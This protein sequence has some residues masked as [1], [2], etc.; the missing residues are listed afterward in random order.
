MHVRERDPRHADARS[1]L[2]AYLEELGARLGGYDAPA[3]DELE[4]TFIA[5]DGDRAV[6]CGSLRRHDDRSAE[7]KRMFVVREARGRG[8]ARLILHALE[9]KARALGYA[10][11]VLDTAAPLT[12]AAAMYAREGYVDIPRYNDNPVAVRWFEKRL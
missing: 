1:L 6:G 4:I 2:H 3:D 7:V 8:C 9:E 5:Y 12:E 10:R 11:V